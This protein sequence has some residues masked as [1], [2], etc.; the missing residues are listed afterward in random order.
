MGTVTRMSLSM[1]IWMR[2]TWRS[3]SV[4]GSTWSSLIMASRTLG[5]ER[6]LLKMVF[7]ASLRLHDP[8]DVLLIQGQGDAGH[9]LSPYRMAGMNPRL[10]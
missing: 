8:D 1:A 7:S 4:A 2:S 3:S 10:S 6:R 9:G 5:V